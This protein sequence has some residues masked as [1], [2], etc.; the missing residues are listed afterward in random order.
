MPTSVRLTPELEDRLTNLAAR[1]GRTKAFYLRQIISR[2]MDEVEEY[3][4]AESIALRVHSGEER[5]YNSAEVR[6]DLGLED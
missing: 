4:L 3:F 6:R 1:T 5:T 2:G